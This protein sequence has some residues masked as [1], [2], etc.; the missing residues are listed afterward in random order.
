VYAK[1]ELNTGVVDMGGK[2]PLELLTPTAKLPPAVVD[3]GGKLPLELLT[4]TARLLTW[5]ANYRW[6]C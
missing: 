4:P 1:R 5:V 6:S 3:M 2:L